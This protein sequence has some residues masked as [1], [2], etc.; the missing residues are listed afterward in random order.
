MYNCINYDFGKNWN[1]IIPYLATKEM[2]NLLK[3]THYER[4]WSHDYPENWHYKDDQAP[5]SL[6]TS[7]DSHCTMMETMFEAVL[8]QKDPR[9][10]S[11]LLK[12]IKK[13][14]YT[15]DNAEEYW[16]KYQDLEEK[17]EIA[18]G[19]N[20]KHSPNHI[21][22]WVPFGCCH[23]FNK[24][25]GMYLA[26]KISPE[27]DWKLLSTDT[28]TTVI[29]KDG[30]Y[31]F[32]LLG[33]SYNHDRFQAICCNEPYVEVDPSLGANE[34]IELLMKQN[35]VR[36]TSILGRAIDFDPGK[37]LQEYIDNKELEYDRYVIN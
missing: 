26:K 27:I 5:A 33:Y 30:K 7:Y 36:F 28:H 16:D 29:S 13:L 2:K 9:I 1:K 18:I 4:K 19:I 6:L 15:D 12:Q 10:P 31:M 17:I 11:I 25:I 23:W 24:F 32:D 3:L 35:N 34:T 21:V 8:E 22:H 14:K 20:Y 37:E